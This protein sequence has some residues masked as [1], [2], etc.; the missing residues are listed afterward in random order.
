MMVSS[1]T[2]YQECFQGKSPKAINEQINLL[3]EE[4][5]GIKRELETE[6]DMGLDERYELY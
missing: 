3:R 1:E 6:E 5:A 4:I 2:Y